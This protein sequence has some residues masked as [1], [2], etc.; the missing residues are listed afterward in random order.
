MAANASHVLVPEGAHAVPM[1]RIPVNAR[2]LALTILAVIAVVGALEVA[3]PLVVSLLLGILAAYALN[4]LVVLLERIRIPRAV[5][6]VVVMVSVMTGRRRLLRG[7]TEAII[8]QLPTQRGLPA[9]WRECAPATSKRA[10]RP[11][12]TQATKQR[13]A[14]KHRRRSSTRGFKFKTRLMANSMGV[15]G[16]LDPAVMVLF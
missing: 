10:P 8:G 12:T 3:Q 16:F 13:P 4:P 14:G 7:Q 15:A 9:R 5:A 6:A 11:Q 2:G 1:V